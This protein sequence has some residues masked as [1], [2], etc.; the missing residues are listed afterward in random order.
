MFILIN[1]IGTLFLQMS[2]MGELAVRS[3]QGTVDRLSG[4]RVRESAKIF[5]KIA[6]RG[7]VVL[8]LSGCVPMSYYSITTVPATVGYET[9]VHNDLILLPEPKEKIPIA[10]YKFVDQTGQYKYNANFSSNSTA[11]TQGATS[12]LVKALE[13]SDWF[14]VVER[15]GLSNLLTE[16]KIV[17][18]TDEEYKASGKKGLPPLSPLMVASVILEGG[19]VAYETNVLTG[20]IGAKYFGAGGSGEYRRDSVTIC[21]RAVNINNGKIL[22]S[23]MTTKTILSKEIDVGIFRF[24]RYK[25]LLEAE[26]GITTNEPTQMCVLEAI[27]KAVYSLIIEGVFD[28]IWSIKRSQDI[29]SL[30]IKKY[31]DEKKLKIIFDKKGNMSLSASSLADTV[32]KESQPS[33]SQTF[34]QTQKSRN[35]QSREKKG[36]KPIARLVPLPSDKEKMKKDELL[37]EFDL[38]REKDKGQGE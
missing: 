7:L 21:L 8:F 26:A 37:K 25:R 38:I 35:R 22:K 3:I 27:E 34:S 10:V 23:V 13:D 31:L 6:A 30:S 33:F 20:G 19:I 11:V 28:H 4:H 2:K 18:S 12:M 1:M 29:A 14:T 15:E 9:A 16:R 17:R 32:K 24:V 36:G 5:T